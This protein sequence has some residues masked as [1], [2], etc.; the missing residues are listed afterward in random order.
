M[1][2][3]ACINNALRFGMAYAIISLYLLLPCMTLHAAEWPCLQQNIQHTGKSTFLGPDTLPVIKWGKHIRG[4]ISGQPVVDQSGRVYFGST[5]GMFFAIANDGREY[6]VNLGSGIDSTAALG[7]SGTIYVLCKNGNLCALDKGTLSIKWKY[8]TNTPVEWASPVVAHD[9]TIY[10]GSGDGNFYAVSKDGKPRW[11]VLLDSPIKS[12]P[13]IDAS[14]IVYISSINGSLYALTPDGKIKWEKGLRVSPFSSPVISP[15]DGYIYITTVDNTLLAIASDGNTMNVME[16]NSSIY[17]LPA[18]GIHQ[19]IYLGVEDGLCIITKEGMQI[20]STGAIFRSHPIV[21]AKG[22]V[23]IASRSG[24]IYAILPDGKIKWNYQVG[25]TPCPISLGPSDMLFVGDRKGDIYGLASTAKALPQKG[26]KLPDSPKDLQVLSGQTHRSAPTLFWKDA[27]DREDGFIIERKTVGADLC[28]CPDNDYIEMSRVNK[29]ITSFKDTG[30][31]PKTNYSYRVCAYNAG[32][33]SKY[34]NEVTLTTPQ[35][36]PPPPTSL[37]VNTKGTQTILAW[38]DTASNE[39]G[40]LLERLIDGTYTELCKL[41][42]DTVKYQDNN[43]IPDTD[44]SYRILSF[45]EAGLS[46]YSNESLVHTPK[47]PP[48]PPDMLVLTRFNKQEIIV[49]WHDNSQNE[50][51]FILEKKIN[52]GTFTTI[53]S[54]KPDSLRFTDK[55]VKINNIYFYRVCSYNATHKSEYSN[56]LEVNTAPKLPNLPGDFKAASVSSTKGVFLT[57]LDTSNNENGFKIVK[58][59]KGQ[60]E[61]KLVCTLEPNTTNY[62]DI[63]VKY[64]I[65]Y[66]Y[67]IVSFNDFGRLEYTQP[68]LVTIPLSPPSEPIAVSALLVEPTQI[69]ITWKDTA[70]NE[71]GFKVQRKALGEDGFAPIVRLDP[72]STQYIDTNLLP[73]TNY[74][75]QVVSYNKS[76]E[77]I[78]DVVSIKTSRGLPQ[79]PSGLRVA[80]ISMM[81]I[82]LSWVGNGDRAGFRLERR[83]EN[84]PYEEIATIGSAITTYRDTE[85]LPNIVYFYRI[86]S[87]SMSGN[88]KY[89]EEI[90]AITRDTLPFFPSGLN[91]MAGEEGIELSWHD[92]SSNEAGFR[93]ERKQDT[94]FV[95]IASV[96]TNN[97]HYEDKNIGIKTTYIYRV[98]AYNDIGS[99]LYSNEAKISTLGPPLPPSGLN[100]IASGPF[101]INLSWID[102]SNDE[103]GFIIE[104]KI[105]EKFYEIARVSKNNTIFTEI[106]LIP[107]TAYTYRVRSCNK[108]GSSDYSQVVTITT[109]QPPLAPPSNLEASAPQDGCIHLIWQDNP[110]DEAGF[111]LER[112]S[113]DTDFQ[114]IASIASGATSYMDIKL[115]ANSTYHY[116]MNAVKGNEHSIYSNTVVVKTPNTIPKPP[117][118]LILVAASREAIHISWQDN[119]SNETGFRIERAEG[120]STEYK[121]IATVER[122]ICNFEDTDILGRGT[123]QYQVVAYNDIGESQPSNLLIAIALG[124]GEISLLQ[125]SIQHPLSC[126][127]FAPQLKWSFQTGQGIR[128]SSAIL[129]NDKK[130]FFGSTDGKIYCLKSDTGEQLWAYETLKPIVSSPVMDTDDNVIYA[131]SRD[132]YLYSLTTDG[133]LRWKYSIGE[134]VESSPIIHNGVI[135]IISVSGELYA[136]LTNGDIKWSIRLKGQ[137]FSSPVVGLN[138]SV[139]VGVNGNENDSAIYAISEL[140]KIQW[141]YPVTYGIRAAAGVGYDNSIYIGIKDK[142]GDNLYAFSEA[143]ELKWK[144]A[145]SGWINQSVMVGPDGGIYAVSNE[146]TGTSKIYRI[147]D[148][149]QSDWHH[150]IGWI[151]SAPSIDSSGIMYIG[152][153]ST[154]YA[155][156]KDGEIIWAYTSKSRIAS[157]PTISTDGM[158]YFGCMDGKM[159]ALEGGSSPPDAP[160]SLS[161]RVCSSKGAELSWIDNSNNETGFVIERKTGEG[162]FNVVT[163]VPVNTTKFTD[164]GL[165]AVTKYE[166][167]VAAYNL[168]GESAYSDTCSGKTFSEPI[169]GI[170]AVQII[171]TGKGNSLQIRWKKPGDSNFSHVRLYRSIIQGEIGSLVR[172]NITTD[173]IID[174]NLVANLM[175]YYTLKAVDRHG[176]EVLS[177]RQ[178]SGATGG[179]GR[180]VVR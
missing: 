22:V 59:E 7:Q 156:N 20:V 76:G 39:S 2:I 18:F 128:N 79:P 56:I 90:K 33:I 83:R 162:E 147:N 69:K 96:P 153:D 127:E 124:Q 65:T 103:E 37:Q 36:P 51:G 159:Y 143:G 173:Y 95:E 134:S 61:Y 133:R 130:L 148:Q 80:N 49:S 9:E 27:G 142:N 170:E 4:Y 115:V 58:S 117:D 8:P 57:W 42:P 77:G 105:R 178:Y 6:S 107:K 52:N 48:S 24:N 154:I 145:T 28:V 11:N 38:Q 149:G 35:I 135:Y 19:E 141:K 5:E 12:T 60:K 166:Y 97:S 62:E 16:I 180:K 150:Q 23:Y 93:I 138:G 132:G 55:Q 71:S 167:R 78:S 81:D 169:E 86:C 54:L 15:D 46:G 118:N 44:Y 126:E 47:I 152:G 175:Y 163:D 63:R 102:N 91:A 3:N 67:R 34:S 119:S 113:Q 25:I 68:I 114:E 73:D 50:Q 168:K 144:Y 30:L 13:A 158:V 89:S 85:V 64:G 151:Y 14:G 112:A 17:S 161:I 140:G 43:L 110:D 21:D 66:R 109:T 160:S 179:R 92:N 155:M 29:N 129:S 94:Q 176:I 100:G 87:Y 164:T 116:R 165:L 157:S 123:Y 171:D 74:S 136:F 104:K 53:S 98:I 31:L 40:F 72:N 146:P 99:S 108:F 131:G 26:V 122:N 101:Q 174:E 75:Y 120:G 125:K 137:G 82:C 70:V 84:A 172:D 88:S 45:N 106:N 1:T 121:V 177:T 10:F 111:V 139:F 32:G 41:A